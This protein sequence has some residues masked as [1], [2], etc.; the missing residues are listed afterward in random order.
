[1]LRAYRSGRG[2]VILA[3]ESVRDPLHV[4]AGAAIACDLGEQHRNELA[5][6][7]ARLDRWHGQSLSAHAFA[8]A[9]VGHMRP[10]DG[11][12]YIGASEVM[13]ADPTPGRSA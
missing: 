1:M 4:L 8:A 2:S 3:V 7:S 5:P 10:H 11:H 9:Q 13:P 12:S 6:S